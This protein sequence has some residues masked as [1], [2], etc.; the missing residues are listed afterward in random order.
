MNHVE[1]AIVLA[2]IAVAVNI[3]FS[4][5]GTGDRGRP[6]PSVEPSTDVC[7]PNN[8]VPCGVHTL[9]FCG[10]TLTY[11]GRLMAGLLDLGPDALVIRSCRSGAAGTGRVRPRV[12]S[13]SSFHAVRGAYDSAPDWSPPHPASRKLDRVDDRRAGMCPR[14]PEPSCSSSCPGGPNATSATRS[15]ARSSAGVPHCPQRRSATTR[16]A[17]NPGRCGIAAFDRVMESAGV[18]SWLE[19]QFLSLIKAARAPQ[20]RGP[21]QRT[22]RADG[23]HI[24]ASTSISSAPR[25]RRGRRP[26]GLLSLD[27]VGDRNVAATRSNSSGSTIYFFTTED[28]LEDGPYVLDTVTGAS[29]RWLT[30]HP[31]AASAGGMS[32]AGSKQSAPYPG[33]GAPA[34]HRPTGS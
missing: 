2:F 28:V 14:A 34:G 13:S 3:R 21:V 22:F 24:A 11:R 32:P 31:A 33:S 8:S 17:R 16:R 15:T 6:L 19:R 10:S 1:L 23:Q 30:Y 7:S 26:P 27:D 20:T 9:R 5:A 4:V 18:Q 12:A 29:R 25:C